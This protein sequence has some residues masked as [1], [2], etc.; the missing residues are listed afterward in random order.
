MP[1]NEIFDWPLPSGRWRS[2]EA[3]AFPVTAYRYDKRGPLEVL[4]K[5]FRGTPVYPNRLAAR[6]FGERTLVAS[7]SPEG[8]EKSWQ[9]HS[10]RYRQPIIRERRGSSDSAYESIDG[11]AP[12]QDP[13]EVDNLYRIRTDT[14]NA[15]AVGDLSKEFSDGFTRYSFL[16]SRA[17]A[18]E[19]TQISNEM[20]S[21][22]QI[23][24]FHLQK[25]LIESTQGA[26]D[27]IHIKSTLKSAA[28]IAQR[29]VGPVADVAA[30][31]FEHV[32]AEYLDLDF[33][34]F[35]LI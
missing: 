20:M 23:P 28:E 27:E 26:M 31:S 19:A 17:S 25:R 4:Q 6:S 13:L 12:W 3:E 1:Q 32:G 21:P 11:E 30:E 7:A 18:F 8:A 14:H 29:R 24:Q 35:S 9:Y 2:F 22:R 33:A 16:N 5:S 10:E 15:V 34:A